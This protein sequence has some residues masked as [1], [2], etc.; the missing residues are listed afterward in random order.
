MHD[1]PDPYP[2]KLSAQRDAEIGKQV[3]LR[4]HRLIDKLAQQQ[5]IDTRTAADYLLAGA[6]L[7]AANRRDFDLHGVRELSNCLLD[8]MLLDELQN[9]TVQ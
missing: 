7:A 2:M 8:S 5:Q 4:L 3:F 6:M 1:D 9:D